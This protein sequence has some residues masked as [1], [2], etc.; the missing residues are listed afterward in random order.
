MVRLPDAI[1]ETSQRQNL[2]LRGSSEAQF[3]VPDWGDKVNYGI[4]LSILPLL[5]PAQLYRAT[6][7]PNVHV[8]RVTSAPEAHVVRAQVVPMFM[9]S[10]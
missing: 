4:G 9:C 1:E 2:R 10:P 7:R 6:T 8:T 3:I 5:A